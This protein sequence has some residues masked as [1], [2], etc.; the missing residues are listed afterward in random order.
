MKKDDMHIS[1]VI[2]VSAL[3]VILGELL[4]RYFVPNGLDHMSVYDKL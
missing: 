1:E 4:I 3:N 2:A